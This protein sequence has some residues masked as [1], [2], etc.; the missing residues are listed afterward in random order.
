MKQG[1]QYLKVIMLVL[2][3]MIASY[4][5]YNVISSASTGVVTIQAALYSTAEEASVSG[6]IVREEQP[7]TAAFHTVSPTRTEGEKVAKGADIAIS[8]QNDAAKNRLLEISQLEE[9]L[10]QLRLAL[11]YQSQFTDTN[12]LSTQISQNIAAFS[13]DV[14]RQNLSGAD[15]EG[16]TLKSLVLR[17][18]IGSQD[19]RTLN[20]QLSDTEAKLE[21][22]RAQSRSDTAT[23][24]AEASGYYSAVVDG[25]E[26]ILTPELLETMTLENFRN[27]WKQEVAAPAGGVGRLITSDNWYFVTEVESALLKDLASGDTLAVSLSSDSR[28][29]ISMEI[30]SAQG[31]SDGKTLLVLKCNNYISAVS[32]L[33]RQ[34]ARIVF[35]AYSGLRIPKEA[36]GYSEEEGSAGV[37]ILEGAKARWKNVTLL[38]DGGDYYIAKLD[39][40]STSN[41]WPEDE[42]ILD[43]KGIT[44]GMLVN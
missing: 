19:A 22:L 37:Y 13:M 31:E 10:S 24:T 26:T 43:A 14:A 39:K 18:T 23:I 35:H 12:A 3:L 33:R 4:L 32:A 9:Q 40:S 16:E 36:I 28:K 6:F 2:A 30:V 38:Y 11:T 25:Y 20:Q 7:I 17:Q 34:N 15:T 29:E 42:I 21:T 5:L 8:L 44:D 1:R 27:L 41:L